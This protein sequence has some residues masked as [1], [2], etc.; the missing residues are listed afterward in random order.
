M[1]QD[2]IG[3]TVQLP[4]DQFAFNAA[5]DAAAAAAA[6]GSEDAAAATSN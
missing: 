2:E 3:L 1:Q 6:A 5:A 4:P